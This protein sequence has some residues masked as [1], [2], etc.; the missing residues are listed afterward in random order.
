M[1]RFARI[2]RRTNPANINGANK[3]L[4]WK[5]QD[6]AQSLVSVHTLYDEVRNQTV[7]IGK[8]IGMESTTIRDTNRDGN[9]KENVSKQKI[10]LIRRRAL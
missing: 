7:F 9:G 8:F 2:N 5:L 1:K 6:R 10:D 3:D 4:C